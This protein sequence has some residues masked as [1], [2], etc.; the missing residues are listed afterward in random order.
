MDQ[1]PN[2]QSTIWIADSDYY[3]FR[4]SSSFVQNLLNDSAAG[5][6]IRQNLFRFK[7]VA[8]YKKIYYIVSFLLIIFYL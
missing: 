6:L 5:T 7:N 8:D 2:P 3:F 1:N 4:S